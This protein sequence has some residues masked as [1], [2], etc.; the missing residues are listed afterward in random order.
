MLDSSAPRLPRSVLYAVTVLALSIVVFEIALTRVFAILMWHHF[1]YMVV[2]VALLGFGAAGSF[3]TARGEGL[4]HGAAERRLARLAAAYG[5]SVVGALWLAMRV[6]ID[7]LNLLREPSNLALL[8]LLYVLI[9]V[10]FVFGGMALG[11]ALTRYAAEVHRLYFFDLAGSA[12]GAALSVFLLATAGASATVVI[13]GCLG[14]AAAYLFA[15][16]APGRGALAYLPWLGAAAI[17]AALFAAGTVSWP[18]PLAPHKELSS[19]ASAHADVR[20]PSATAEVEVSD[21]F[22]NQEPVIGGNFGEVDKSRVALRVVAQDGTAPTAMYENAADVGRF[23]FL[24]DTQAASAYRTLLA[25]GGAEPAVL[26]IGVGGGID[27]M[28]ALA[29]GAARVDAVEINGAMIEMVT[30]RYDAYLGGLFRPGAH[31]LADRVKLHHG[32]GR[33]YLR[34]SERRYDVIQM[35]GVDSFTALSTGA[36]TLSESYL[37]TVEAVQDFYGHLEDGGYVNYSRFIITPPQ[38]LP[39]ETLRLAHIALEA[40]RRL[41]VPNPASQLAVF[42]GHNWASTLIKRGAFTA[43]EIAAL[44]EFAAQEGFR[45]L[46]F[47]PLH[48]PGEPFPVPGDRVLQARAHFSSWIG[49][50]AALDAAGAPDRDLLAAMLAAFS[51]RA[52]RGPGGATDAALA[53]ASSR[54]AALGKAEFDAALRGAIATA[55]EVVQPETERHAGVCRIFHGLLGAG[56]VERARFVADY[57]YDLTPCTDDSPFFFNYY[58]YSGLLGQLDAKVDS[59]GPRP[60]TEYHPEYPVGH[61]VLMVSMLQIVLLAAVLLFLPLWRLRARGVPTQGRLSYLA[62]FSALG[63]GFMTIEIVLMQKVVIFLGHPTYCISVVLVAL[64]GF[65]GIG[66]RISERVAAT[67]RTSLALI[68][69]LIAALIAATTVAIN[70]VPPLLLGFPLAGRIAAVVVL[71]LPLGIAL[72]LPFPLGMRVL[73]QNCPQLLPWGWAVNGFASVFASLFSIVLSMA[74]GFSTVLAVAALVYLGGFAALIRVLR[75]APAAAAA[76]AAV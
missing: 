28:V 50:T 63:A 74:F 1:T 24:D 45:G 13:A 34:H 48:P 12:A 5:V 59:G 42:Q 71:L 33:S 70:A 39:R 73:K 69:G 23:P 22:S 58:R 11:L 64:L 46:V 16:A 56:D 49:K 6:P 32:E 25:R 35:S 54:L 7:T 55:A 52:T 76:N 20:L 75:R 40:L 53:A 26:V 72:G 4:E 37:Y 43:A 15:T 21:A 67:S 41:D 9:T 36:Y 14:V 27:V 66:A 8:L 68:A 19:G 61:A 18:V 47:D 62:Y 44:R 10:P 17:V 38:G 2:S 31:P 65:A 29:H 60:D 3:L 57:P 30:E 51:A